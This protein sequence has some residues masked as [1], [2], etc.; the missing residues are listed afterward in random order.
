MVRRITQEIHEKLQHLAIE[1]SDRHIIPMSEQYPDQTF[2]IRTLGHIWALLRYRDLVEAFQSGTGRTKDEAFSEL[3]EAEER[4]DVFLEMILSLVTPEGEVFASILQNI[5]RIEAKNRY[6]QLE[7]LLTKRA[8]HMHLGSDSCAM[9]ARIDQLWFQMHGETDIEVGIVQSDR[10]REEIMKAFDL[11]EQ[12]DQQ[13]D[14][15]VKG[16]KKTNKAPW[17]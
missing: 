2:N 6:E 3:L 11:N 16:F 9:L 10:L 8:K 4:S 12:V 17:N 15:V 14:T 5:H 7:A 1:K 13:V